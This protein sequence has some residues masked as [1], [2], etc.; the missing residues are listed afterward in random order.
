[1]K[2]EGEYTVAAPRERVWTLLNDPGVLQ[3]ATPGVKE[4]QPIGEDT[5]RAVIELA[6]GP[7]RGTFEGKITITEKVPPE[8]VTMIVEGSG[9]PGTLKARGDLQ[10]VA[11]NGST[12]VRYTGDA[13][14][15]GV[16]MSVGHR[17]FGGVAKEMA[18][19]FFS[20]LAREIEHAASR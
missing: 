16:L 11:Q 15:T 4:L 10:L 5:Y 7:V 20:A 3:R 19:K 17:L 1:M 8:R 13:Q 12:L 6:V 18:G 14:V 9:R 2:V